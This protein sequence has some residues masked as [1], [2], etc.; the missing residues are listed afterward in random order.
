MFFFSLL[1]V[2]AFLYP[3]T[4]QY[5]SVAELKAAETILIQEYD[6]ILLSK[7]HMSPATSNNIVTLSNNAEQSMKPSS[8]DCLKKSMNYLL[9]LCL[10]QKPPVPKTINSSMK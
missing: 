2:T 9:G 1:Q 4:K 10:V 6:E 5:L 7:T 8:K 3:Y